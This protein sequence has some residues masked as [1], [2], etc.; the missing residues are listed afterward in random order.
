M[1]QAAGPSLERSV[2][3]S[4][5]V[6]ASDP[7]NHS[8]L[9]DGCADIVWLPDDSLRVIGPMTRQQTFRFP[10][11]ARIVGVR[12]RPGMAATYLRTAPS[13]VTDTSA[14]LEDLWGRSARELRQRIAEAESVD[15][16]R[17]LLLSSLAP[18]PT[19][20]FLQRA[21]EFISRQNGIIDL[22]FVARQANLSPRQFRRRCLE[23]T[24]LTP[25]HLCRILRFRNARL[26]AAASARPIWSDIAL[27]AGYF[28]QSH[29]IRD[30]LE[31]TGQTPVSV[32]SNTEIGQ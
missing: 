12:F 8:V 19:P 21:I 28:D 29:L 32:F 16:A 3:C 22:E 30:F 17:S 25:K 26:L 15:E 14:T 9:P 31:F 18:P 10:S 6:V 11:G 23:E 24:G 27:E 4:W 2:E 7:G 5:S 20:T 1:E 13:E